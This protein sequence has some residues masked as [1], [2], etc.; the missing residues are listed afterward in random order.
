MH[1]NM[2]KEKRHIGNESEGAAFLV[3]PTRISDFLSWVRSSYLTHVILP[4]LSGGFGTHAVL[5]V[6][7]SF[8]TDIFANSGIF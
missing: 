5:Y 3:H 4:M 6:T 7:T 8:I 1:S 2:H